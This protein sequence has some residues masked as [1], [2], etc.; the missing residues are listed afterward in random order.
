MYNYLKEYPEALKKKFYDTYGGEEEFSYRTASPVLGNLNSGMQLYRI[1]YEKP[2]LFR[3][4]KHALHLPQYL[5]FLISGNVCSDITSIGCHTN[6]WDFLKNEYHYWVRQEGVLEKLA[7]LFP[8]N[9]VLPAFFPGNNYSVGIGLHDSSAALIPYLVNF[10]EPFILISTGTWCIS[11]NPF[12]DSP[13][14]KE[15]LENDCLCYMTYLGKPVKASRLFAGYEHEQQVKRI[16]EY[17]HQNAGSYKDME[18][19]PKIIAR[20]QETDKPQKKI[21]DTKNKLKTSGFSSRELSDFSNYEEAYHQLI[22]DIVTQQHAS[23]QMVLKGT[24]VKRIF[25]DGGFSKNA[26]YMNL[27][28]AFFPRYRSLCS[29]CGAGNSVRHCTFHS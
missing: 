27:L 11:L 3:Q 28:A 5:S 2:Q 16:V 9:T 15:E 23:T 7:P 25:V 4:I 29:I 10:H 26:I 24:A 1:K 22:L 8:C 12:N 19:N 21:P 17:F 20:L 18:Y 13:L 6:L 14:T